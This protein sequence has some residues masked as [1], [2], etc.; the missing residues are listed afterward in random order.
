MR[1]AARDERAFGLVLT[2]AIPASV[3]LLLPLVLT[4]MPG[5]VQSAI[6]ELDGVLALCALV[7]ANAHSALPPLG[8]V[9][10]GLTAVTATMGSLRIGRAL[11]STVRVRR[12]RVEIAVPARL[13]RVADR[14]GIAAVVCCADP[15]PYAY[16]AGLVAPRI[17]VSTGAVAALRE[18]ELEAVLLH[19]RHHQSRRDPLRVLVGRA[20]A[21][22][23]FAVPV[24]A[25][26]QRRFELAK[27]LDADRATLIAHGGRPAALA[28]AL[29]ALGDGTVPFR[30]Q[31]AAAG[32]WSLTSVR[33]D[34]LVDPDATRLPR[35][36]RRAVAASL[37][38]LALAVGLGLGQAARAHVI[39][40]GV[41]PE[42]APAAHRCP[43]P[44]DGPLL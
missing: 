14:L 8:I 19:E 16:C 42:S 28:G 1:R 13:R 2:A 20:A 7:L 27:E 41:L 11:A 15:R 18:P 39:P 33:I 34:Q 22:L 17:Y 31:D 32:A 6:H 5:A 29:L 30:T 9:V 21:A 23:L 26:L 10:L 40:A 24:V 37:A 43:V 25:E 12:E 35:P 44:Y 3:V 4:V 36:S 38:T